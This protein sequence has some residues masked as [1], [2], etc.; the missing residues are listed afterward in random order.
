MANL[1]NVCSR[2]RPVLHE[3][4]GF[5]FSLGLKTQVKKKKET[6]TGGKL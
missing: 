4:T 5:F 3:H 1:T 6:T 2:G